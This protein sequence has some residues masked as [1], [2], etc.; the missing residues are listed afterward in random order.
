MPQ[1]YHHVTRDIRSQIYAL[2]ATGTSLHKIAA[3]NCNN[4]SGYAAA[5][6]TADRHLSAHSSLCIVARSCNNGF[7][8]SLDHRMCC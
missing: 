4:T 2:K 5:L 7:R 1:G 8:P 6:N 3:R